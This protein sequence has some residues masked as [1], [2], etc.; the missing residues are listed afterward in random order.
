MTDIPDR[1]TDVEFCSVCGGMIEAGG[2]SDCLC[3]P[4]DYGDYLYHRE[5]DEE[6]EKRTE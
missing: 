3:D 5:R 2:D 6:A 1:C 4:D